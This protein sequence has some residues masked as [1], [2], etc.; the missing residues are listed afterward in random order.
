MTQSENIVSCVVRGFPVDRVSM[1][2]ID[3]KEPKLL[4]EWTLGDIS[5]SSEEVGEVI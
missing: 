4:E 3:K 5:D 2:S 1:Y